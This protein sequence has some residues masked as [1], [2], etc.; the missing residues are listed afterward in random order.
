MTQPDLVA[1]TG[2]RGTEALEEARRTLQ[3]C[4]ACRYC[5]GYCAV[6]PAMTRRRAFLD[7]DIIHLANLCHGCRDCFHACQYAPPHEF[8]INAP[9][10]F[11]EVRLDSYRTSS[12]APAFAFARP[13]IFALLV[14]CLAVAATEALRRIFGGDVSGRGFY[15]V[16]G[17]DAMISF[18]MIV[19]TA[20]AIGLLA[21]VWRY[22]MLVSTANLTRPS[23]ANWLSAVRDA[24][25]L[26]N[27]GGG[28]VGCNDA[29]ETFGQRRRVLHHLMAG[30][31]TACFAATSVGAYYDHFLGW[32]AP[33]P[34]LSA[35]GVLGTVG[36]LAII[37]GTVGLLWLKR[38]EMS[39]PTSQGMNAIDHVTLLLLL[40]V[41]VTGLALRGSADGAML[42]S[43]VVLHLGS[44]AAFLVILPI[45]KF[46]HAPLRLMAL[47][48][49]AEERSKVDQ[50]A[51]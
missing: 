41:A 3:I 9:R 23:P 16:L 10:T 42:T 47:A 48:R 17:R 20:S 49:D 43:M 45:G 19:A 1:M 2:A 34:L 5:E 24:A 39:E 40:T 38:V 7:A 37:A 27:L 13:Y 26:R 29:D 8:A 31:F 25:T 32:Q 18:G 22:R 30:G 50:S 14:S 44:V 21:A 6:F 12:P 36:G 33:Y 51:I 11:A 4:N 15:A 28:G 46:V 35:P